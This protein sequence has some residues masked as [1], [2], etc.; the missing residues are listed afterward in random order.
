MNGASSICR[1]ST[2]PGNPRSFSGWSRRGRAPMT[3]LSSAARAIRR[4]RRP[5]ASSSGN[6]DSGAGCSLLHRTNPKYA[7]RPVGRGIRW[8]CTAGRPFFHPGEASPGRR[9]PRPPEAPPC[10]IH[11]NT[12][13]GSIYPPGRGVRGSGEQPFQRAADLRPNVHRMDKPGG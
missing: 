6:P 12:R 3:G 7:E 11:K 8:H 4:L 1:S 5:G 13:R 10:C 2:I 9:I